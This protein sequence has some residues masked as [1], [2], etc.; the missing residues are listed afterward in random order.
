[1][2]VINV[3]FWT[4]MVLDTHTVLVIDQLIVGVCLFMGFVDSKK[5]KSRGVI[6]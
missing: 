5:I 1:M 3:C 2:Y 4:I 6:L